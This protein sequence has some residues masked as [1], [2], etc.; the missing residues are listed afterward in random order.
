MATLNG[1]RLS[2]DWSL[3]DPD[4][5]VWPTGKAL[6]HC[7]RVGTEKAA[8]WSQLIGANRGRSETVEKQKNLGGT[9][10]RNRWN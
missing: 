6:R 9:G 7:E 5:R 2:R 3:V 1:F 10:L 8:R 4:G